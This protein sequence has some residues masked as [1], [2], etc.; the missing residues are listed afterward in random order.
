MTKQR[1][2]AHL[3]TGRSVKSAWKNVE[4]PSPLTDAQIVGS[5]LNDGTTYVMELPNGDFSA[6]NSAHV[7]SVVV[8]TWR[9][10][11]YGASGNSG[12]EFDLDGNA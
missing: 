6:F 8:E 7:V 10:K 12:I 2:V 11:S 9:E 1:T 5:L 3:T 4:D